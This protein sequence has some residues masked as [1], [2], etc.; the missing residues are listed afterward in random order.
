MTAWPNPALPLRTRQRTARLTVPHYGSPQDGSR[1]GGVRAA[2]YCQQLERGEIL[3]FART[4]FALPRHDCAFL[5]EQARGGSRLHKNVSYRPEADAL[6]GFSGPAE[7]Q[8]N[9]R[10]ILR[11]YSD[12]AT[13]F[14]NRFLSP[15]A[16]KAMRDYA[17]FR[18]L[19]EEGR[20]LPVH[21]RNDLLHI[22]AFPTR[23][24]RGGRILRVFT[25][26]HPFRSRV[27]RTDGPFSALAQR[28]AAAAG[29]HEMREP[30]FRNRAMS[31]L[32]A[33]GLRIPERSRYDRFMLRFHDFLKENAGYQGRNDGEQVEF[34]P[35]STWM[36]YT[37]GVAHAVLSGQFALEQTF[38]V[39]VE[40]LVSPAD[41]PLRIL[42][43]MAGEALV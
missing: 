13:G 7:A 9:A 3:F 18:P 40:A 6:R 21:K 1:D 38:V 30:K 24:T 2:H 15:Y 33:A 37:D 28:Y 26:I 23:P 11:E 12:A 22:D 16:G 27:W 36:V 32:R 34:P 4:P 25:N 14:V 20:D 39:P 41:S 5:M 35:M 8:E 10:R 31:W 19:E 17:S 43:D 42:E 29:L